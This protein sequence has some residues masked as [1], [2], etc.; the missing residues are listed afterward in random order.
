MILFLVL[1]LSIGL[2]AWGIWQSHKSEWVG[3]GVEARVIG[4][5]G[6]VVIG[7]VSIICFT[8]NLDT[9]NKMESF[10]NTNRGNYEV[11]SDDIA[12]Y[13]SLPSSNVVDGSV[14]KFQMMTEIAAV[15]RELLTK[16]NEYNTALYAFRRYDKNIWYGIYYPTPP[17]YLKPIV[18]KK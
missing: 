1:G 5:I 7:V 18:L 11:T 8:A 13:F 3:D 10:Y 4:I 14:E 17:D 15:K 9:M 6:I 12:S 16:V 2:I